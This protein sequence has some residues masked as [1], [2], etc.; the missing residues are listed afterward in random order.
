MS[1]ALTVGALAVL[2]ASALG[3]TAP[4]AQ[5]ALTT[6][7]LRPDQAK[8]TLFEALGSGRLYQQAAKTAFQ[9]AASDE[10]RV[11]LVT[12]ALTWAKEY[13][14]SPDFARRYVTTRTAAEPRLSMGRK[15][16]AEEELSRRQDPPR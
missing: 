6:L 10:A 3:A 13:S 16:S 9:T 4:V 7:G 15:W 11:A 2:V 8:T 5:E 1:R 12:G 14:G